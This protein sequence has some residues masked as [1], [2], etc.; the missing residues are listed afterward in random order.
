[1]EPTPESPPIVQRRPEAVRRGLVVDDDRGVRHLISRMLGMEGLEVDWASDG[2]EGLRLAMAASYEVVFLDLRLPKLDGMVVLRRLLSARPGQAVIV[3]S[4][5]SDL[6]TRAECLC[7]GARGFLAK[8]FSLVDLSTSVAGA[9][10]Y[11]AAASRGT[12]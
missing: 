1:M 7:A 8:P 10:G 9:R 11:P 2:E 3:S 5:Q 4:C 12:A 6:G